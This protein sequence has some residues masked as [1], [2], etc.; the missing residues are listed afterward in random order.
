MASDTFF[1]YKRYRWF[2]ICAVSLIIA[3]IY[4]LGDASIV[5]ASGGTTLGYIYGIVAALGI[6]YLLWYGVR[7]RSYSARFTTLKGCLSA[8]VWIGL[9]LLI[10]VPLHSGFQFG[11]NIHTLAYVLMVIVILS[12]F[13][14]AVQYVKLAYQIES[15]RGNGTLP[16]LI[17]Q[18]YLL[19]DEIERG[20]QNLSDGAAKIIYS[21]DLTF[22]PSI[23]SSFHKLPQ[24]SR[25]ALAQAIATLPEGERS[26][27][28]ALTEQVIS[29]RSLIERVSKEVRVSSLLKFWL[30]IHVPVSIA[31]FLSVIVHIIA[32][33][34]FR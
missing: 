33:L 34:F 16:A 12:G 2:W 18:V 29:K 31:L 8:H 25:E 3:I 30:Y 28:L 32:V 17:D 27:V 7:K 5:V 10:L 24:L 14:G 15:H 4:Y 1:S 21:I 26:T 20:T 13:W 22:K 23:L 19:S 9:A 6:L 11:A